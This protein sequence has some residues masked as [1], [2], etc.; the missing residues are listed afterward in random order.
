[1]SSSTSLHFPVNLHRNLIP[2]SPKLYLKNLVNSHTQTLGNRKQISTITYA[3][4]TPQHSVALENSRSTRY[5]KRW[6]HFVG[7]GGCGLSALAMLAL[8]QGFEVSGSDIVWSNY[9]DGLKQAGAGLNLD[10]SVSNLQRDNG[11][12]FP[13]AVIVSSAIPPDNVEILYAKSLGIPVYKRGQWLG[14]TTEGYKLIAISGTHGKSTTASMLAYVLK[15]M[16]ED[17]TAV[18]GAQVPQ[19]GGE[20]AI[21]GGG[22]SFVLEADEYDGCFLGLS[23][24]IAVVTNV[25]WEHVDIFPDEVS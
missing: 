24:Y 14:R 25:D 20:N 17:I 15:A 12:A 21:F 2:R 23:P 18:V 4:N 13:T 16:G 11:L 9:M 5:E 6:I 19:F 8:K 1:M 3:C 7:I 10:H 22:Q